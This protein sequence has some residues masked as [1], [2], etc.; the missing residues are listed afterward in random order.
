MGA[1]RFFSRGAFLFGLHCRFSEGFQ[2]LRRGSLTVRRRC[3]LQEPAPQ[4]RQNLGSILSGPELVA[5]LSPCK[6]QTILILDY[7]N[8]F[9][10][11]VTFITNDSFAAS[12][13]MV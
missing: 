5:R 4:L 3:H 7:L 1:A 6:E 10:S 11:F 2:K 12:Y 8:I 13:L 9:L